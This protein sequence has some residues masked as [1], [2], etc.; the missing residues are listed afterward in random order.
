[1]EDVYSDNSTNNADNDDNDS[2]VQENY[3]DMLMD[4]GEVTL[5]NQYQNQ[6]EDDI[7]QEFI[8]STN[9]G[10]LLFQV[11]EESPKGCYVNGHVILNQYVVAQFITIKATSHRDISFSEL[12]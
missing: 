10:E 12:F 7:M 4:P 9:Q 8:P 1:M 2:I 3:D 6:D 11:V 5:P